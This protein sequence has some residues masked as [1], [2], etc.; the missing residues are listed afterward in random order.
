[1]FFDRM[2]STEALAFSFALGHFRDLA[3]MSQKPT[4]SLGWGS[5]K[6]DTEPDSAIMLATMGSLVQA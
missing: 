3:A 4:L 1:M 6:L 5:A 2:Q